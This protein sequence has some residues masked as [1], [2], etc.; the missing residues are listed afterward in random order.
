MHWRSNIPIGRFTIQFSHK[1]VHTIHRFVE[2]I[3]WL[4]N[5]IPIYLYM[6]ARAYVHICVWA[7]PMFSTTL[8]MKKKGKENKSKWIKWN[9]NKKRTFTWQID[10]ILK[11]NV[12]SNLNVLFKSTYFWKCA[13]FTITIIEVFY[14][15]QKIIPNKLTYSLCQ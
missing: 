12:G 6:Y 3:T 4:F 7:H 14:W 11:L 10:A 1:S 2:R 8:C 15:K 9:V 13:C 5:P